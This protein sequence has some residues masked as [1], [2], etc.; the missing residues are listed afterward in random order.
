MRHLPGEIVRPEDV[1]S[2]SGLR[3]GERELPIVEWDME[4]SVSHM[5]EVGR[6]RGIFQKGKRDNTA[7]MTRDR[8]HETMAS[9][10]TPSETEDRGSVSF[11]LPGTM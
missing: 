1:A 6:E 8:A 2:L 11:L 3:G 4:V 5:P 10:V 9:Q 7:E